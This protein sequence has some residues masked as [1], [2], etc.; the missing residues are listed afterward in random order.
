MNSKNKQSLL[1]CVSILAKN[2]QQTI[3]IPIF[4]DTVAAGF[5]SPAQDFIEKRI[6][7]NELLIK[8]PAATY[9]LKVSGESMINDHIQDGDLVIVDSA[10]EAK[11]G[12]I[13]IASILGEFTIKKL[14]TTPKLMLKPMNPNFNP[15]MIPNPDE[16]NIFGVVTYIIHKV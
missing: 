13:V 2:P 6:D 7:L 5:P 16:L 9:I 14:C 15:I 3:N 8:H 10:K 4:L 11:H 12:D 1:E